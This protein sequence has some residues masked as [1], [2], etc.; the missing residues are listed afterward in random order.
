MPTTLIHY[1][2]GTGNTAHAVKMISA[3]LKAAGHEISIVQ[4]RFGAVPPKDTFDF[5]IVAF[6]VLSWAPP[7]MMSRYLKKMPRLNGTKVAI[8][9]I[10]GALLS[11][12]KLIAGYTG[13]ALEEAERILKRKKM[14]VFLTG[15]ASFPDNWT[16]MTNPCDEEGLKVIIPQGEDQVRAF[17]HKFLSEERELYRCG[18]FNTTWSWLVSG[19]F[20]RIGRRLLGT[21]YIADE[22]C[23]GCGICA[24]TCPAQ[25]IVMHRKLPRW[26]SKCED[27]NRCINICPEKA[28]QVSLPLMLLQIVLNLFL[29]VWFIKAVLDYASLLIVGHPW[30]KALVD[31]PLVLLAMYLAVWVSLVPFD[32]VF[33][34]SMK[35]PSVRTYFTK[36]FTKSFRR[37]SAPGFRPWKE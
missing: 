4:V 1:F 28:I 17:I 16:Q 29:S 30:L 23:T 26:K 34:W 22:H 5:H 6:P 15:N 14:D 8:L 37:Y 9:A 36:S 2:T 7:V 24:K 11:N 3:A 13:Q 19:G 31:I 21:F 27:C 32:A 20:G 35:I 12:G 18:A 10:N 25:T 33:R